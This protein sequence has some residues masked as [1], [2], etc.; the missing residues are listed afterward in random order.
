VEDVDREIFKFD[1][2]GLWKGQSPRLYVHVS[3][4]RQ[5]GSDVF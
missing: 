3:P 5:S 4:D 2:C 1:D